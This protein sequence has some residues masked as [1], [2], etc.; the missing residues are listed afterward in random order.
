MSSLL[1]ELRCAARKLSRTPGFT[2]VCVVTLALAI[3]ATTAV[4]SIVNGVLLEPL[5][6]RDPGQV[7]AL[8]SLNKDGKL[9]HLSGPDFIDYRGQTHSFSAVAPFIDGNSAN[10]SVPGAEPRR[11]NAAEV[12]ANFFDLL[13]VPME[14]G[15]GFIA[16]EDK[17]GAQRVAVLSDHLW[18]EQFAA[19][20]HIVGRVI[21]INGN[22]YTVVGV[23]RP[24]LTYPST[25]DLWTPFTFE[26]WMI[27]P[28]NRG[29][30]FI[31]AV[32]R[33]R[34]GVTPDAARRDMK[35]VGD[36]LRAEYPKSN[37]SFGG[38]AEVLQTRMVETASTA[39]LTMLGAVGFV[40]LIACANVANLMLVRAAGR[41]SEIA[42]RTALG[43]GRG[44]II[45]QLVA[46]SLLLSATGAV[47]GAAIAAWIVDGVVAFGPQ[48]L[49][50]LT[51]ISID[52]RV[53]LFSAALALVT[54]LVFGLV[55]AFHA[56]R[57]NLGEVLK[58]GMRG[59]SGGRAAQRTRSG[60]VVAEIALA[61]VLLV[62]AGLLVRSFV[63]L[64]SVDPGFHPENLLS[65]DVT[66]PTAKYPLDRDLRRFTDQLRSDL[67]QVPGVQSVAAT[68]DPPM[69]SHGMSVTFDIEGQP[70]RAADKRM[71]TG[72]LPATAN[73]FATLGIPLV[74]GRTFSAAEE[75]WGVPPVVVV[76]QALVRRYFPNED[77]I[78]KRITLGYTHDTIATTSPVTAGGTIV[79]VV[80]DVRQDGLRAEPAPAT[81]VGWGTLPINDMTFVVRSRDDLA[82]LT[83][84]VRE[85]VHGI[86]SAM[87]I[88][89][90][91]TM[92]HAVSESIAQPRFYTL[93]LGAFASLALL[94]A[95]LGIYGVISYSVSQRTRELGI[96]IA[97]GATKKRVTRL[98]LGQ[99][100]T[101]A[102]VGAVAGIVAAQWLVRLLSAML[103]GV[104]AGDL[105]TFALVSAALIGVAWLA[106]YLPA[107][108]AARVDPVV[109]MR[110]E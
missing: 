39:L 105:T 90:V 101:L 96:R 49:P 4:F 54:G 53:L 46:E 41:E 8:G 38:T 33:L 17:K 59:S 63:K 65:F 22:D 24:S 98:V 106:S 67:S 27:E 83:G 10:L 25:P 61:M 31:N 80:A 40:L 44:R 78:G 81:Y 110:A 85:R 3:G 56:A 19:D 64:S 60:L 6:F 29:A 5:P 109:A 104:G 7:M 77:P 66:L 50:R 69:S 62:G 35:M 16:A 92:E 76:N 52:G 2:I 84:A 43:A 37:A 94:L 89:D 70:A 87:P 12:G 18:R 93:L 20:L 45:R 30:H 36:R 14:L 103:Y 32:A 34:P 21:S 88:Y 95:A 72:V 71:I 51:D 99:G 108:R 47:I 97:L 100:L 15:R 48:G 74:K 68:F 23:A 86:D 42:V 82:T 79:G 91:Q 102:L 28:D 57:T 73:L 75:N 9:V 1:H 13:G 58:S 55:P 107:R 11:L 26:P